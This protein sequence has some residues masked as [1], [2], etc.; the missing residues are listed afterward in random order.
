MERFGIHA[1][2]CTERVS[3][4]RRCVSRP[5]QSSQIKA[6][7]LQQSSLL[8]CPFPFHSQRLGC[9][10]GSEPVGGAPEAASADR[11][12][13]R[14][15]TANR[16]RLWSKHHARSSPPVHHCPRLMRGFNWLYLAMWAHRLVCSESMYRA[17]YCSVDWNDCS[18]KGQ[19]LPWNVLRSYPSNRTWMHHALLMTAGRLCWR[20]P[21]MD[22]SWKKPRF[23]ESFNLVTDDDGY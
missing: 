3:L 5:L 2:S 8:C 7:K 18:D 22:G 9:S 20:V 6:N 10:G 14:N 19:V 21:M 12:A 23:V 16:N 4:G 15:V 17:L 1:A 11:E 13:H